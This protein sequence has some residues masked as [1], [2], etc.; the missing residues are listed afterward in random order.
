M[1]RSALFLCLTASSLLADTPTSTLQPWYE[2][3]FPVRPIAVLTVPD[4]PRQLLLVQQRGQVRLLPAD[5]S[6]VTAPLFLDLSDRHLEADEASKFEEGLV[7][8]TWHPQFATNR[9]CYL[10]YTRQDPKRIVLSEMQ[11][12][13]APSLH[14]DPSTER[15]LLELQLPFWN[16]HSACLCFGTDGLLYITIGDGGGPQGGDPLR[17]AQNPFSLFGKILRLDVDHP[18]G[19][20]AYGIPADNPFVGKPGYREEIYALGVRNPWGLSRAPDGQLWF[21]DVGQNL[22]EEI[23]LVSKA[24]NY[25]WSYREGLIAYPDRA[26]PPP[27]DTKFTD[28]IYQ[29]TR[30]EGTSITGGFIYQGAAF[31]KLRGAYIYG[32]FGSGRLWALHYEATATPATRNE[33][34]YAPH[35]NDKAAPKPTGIYPDAN[36]EILVLDWNGHLNRLRP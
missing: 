22:W 4:A 19:A 7:G 21:C 36:G 11:C 18:T 5:E 23:N 1:S 14:A 16:H 24:A 29:Y 34:L 31:P 32:D 26:D 3:L 17:H 15:I 33:L 27:V 25:G 30:N 20:R 2:E 6:A 28:P 8:M 10:T 13:A 12:P 35:A 9:K